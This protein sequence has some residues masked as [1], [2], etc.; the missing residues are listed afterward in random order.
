[1]KAT[2]V[3]VSIPLSICLINPLVLLQLFPYSKC[4]SLR[5]WYNLSD[6]KVLH[7]FLP[8]DINFFT[9]I[10]LAPVHGDHYLMNLYSGL[11]GQD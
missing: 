2:F 10:K 8:L 5:R 6:V 3:K 4:S 1:M 11:T 7:T 9:E